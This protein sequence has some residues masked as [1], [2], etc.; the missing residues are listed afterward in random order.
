MEVIYCDGCKWDDLYGSY[1]A[2]KP[3]EKCPLCGG[4]LDKADS[5]EDI[6]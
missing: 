5:Y 1:D 2:S 3:L 6:P 4:E